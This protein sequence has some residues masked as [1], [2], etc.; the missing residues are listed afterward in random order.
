MWN[1]KVGNSFEYLFSLQIFFQP[2]PI[3]WPKPRKQGMR[4]SN[5]TSTSKWGIICA[6]SS[7]IWTRPRA[8]TKRGLLLG[9]R[10]AVTRTAHWPTELWRRL[11]ST[12]VGHYSTRKYYFQCFNHSFCGLGE[13]QRAV[14]KIEQSMNYAL[15]SGKPGLIQLIY[16]QQA[17]L[18][19]GVEG[20]IEKVDI[21]WFEYFCD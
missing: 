11:Q 21:F 13:E 15:K 3:V 6:P 7:T 19:S 14:S 12:R 17:Y 4:A 9:R 16:H 2:F 10:L 8:S 20:L 18:F 5:R 1:T